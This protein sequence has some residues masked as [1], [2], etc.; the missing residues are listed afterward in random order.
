MDHLAIM[1]KSWGLTQKILNGTKKIESRWYVN[2]YQPW[3][4]IK[5]GE[6][7]YFKDSGDPVTAMAEVDKVLQFADLTPRRVQE[8]LNQYGH[9][10]GLAKEKIPDFF[11]MFKDKKYCLLIYL[12]N[13]RKIE[14]FEFNKKGFGLM[15]A[16]IIIDDINKYKKL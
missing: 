6:K 10:D 14:P 4:R 2:K 7:V 13:P 15:A 11:K 5:A 9:D 8:I 12:K 16:W 3:D 1:R